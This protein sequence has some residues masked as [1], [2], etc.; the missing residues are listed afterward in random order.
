MKFKYRGKGFKVK[1]FNKLS[2]ITFR[3]GK[4]HW[5]KVLYNKRV[6]Q[7]KRTK[8]NTYCCVTIKNKT[9]NDFKNLIFKIKGINRYTKRG[10]RLTR[11]LV[12]KRFGKISQAS[13]V[14]N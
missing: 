3:L 4:S 8:K 12:K 13:S 2:K 9:F 10:L 6:M 11:Q 5:T 1:K 14:Y 7:V